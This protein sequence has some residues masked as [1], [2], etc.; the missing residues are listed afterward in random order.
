MFHIILSSDI[1]TEKEGSKPRSLQCSWLTFPPPSWVVENQAK[2]DVTREAL[3]C[4]R[5]NLV[6]IFLAHVNTG[7]G[8]LSVR[9]LR[10]LMLDVNHLAS[11][12]EARSTS[13]LLADA[14]LNE[15]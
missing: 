9:K 10:T 6:G 2:L 7:V 3:L 15:V 13:P 11:V 1:M 14:G 5:R 12:N 4:G 8:I